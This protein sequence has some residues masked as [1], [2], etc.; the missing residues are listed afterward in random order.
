MLVTPVCLY[1]RIGFRDILYFKGTLVRRDVNH[2]CQL[3]VFRLMNIY[4]LLL[5]N[6]NS[7]FDFVL[8][9]YFKDSWNIFDFVTVVGSI[10]DATR[11]VNVGFL[12]LFR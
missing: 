9:P 4:S 11:I 3:R 6:Q 5:T 8:Q 2:A 12:R 1:S 7:Y 10:I